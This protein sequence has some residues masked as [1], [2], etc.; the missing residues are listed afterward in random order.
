MSATDPR[1]SRLIDAL[2]THVG[3]KDLEMNDDNVCR[4]VLDGT[5]VLDIEHQPGTDVL[6]AYS[7]VGP[8]PGGNVALCH[9]LLSANLFGRGT[10]GAV[11]GL[12]EQR[13]EV[14]LVH[15]FDLATLTPEKF[16]STLES[17]VGYVQSWTAELQEL[18]GEDDEDEEEE[19]AHGDGASPFIRV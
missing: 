14:L 6:Q 17:F 5:L 18:A 3:V 19:P 7:V 10:G 13:G 15:T 1:I 9:H 8:S 11:L 16:V 2:A 12:D 4:L